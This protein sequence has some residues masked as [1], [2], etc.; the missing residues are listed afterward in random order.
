MWRLSLAITAKYLLQKSRPSRMLS[1][2]QDF[3][4]FQFRVLT[5]VLLKIRG[6]WDVNTRRLVSKYRTAFKFDAKLFK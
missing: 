5:A 6:F 4:Q 1:I 3:K 2:V